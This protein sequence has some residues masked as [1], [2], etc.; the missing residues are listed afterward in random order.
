VGAGSEHC[1]AIAG[2]RTLAEGW[3]SK[4]Q[5]LRKKHDL[6][7]KQ[8]LR[9]R[10]WIINKIAVFRSKIKLPKMKTFLVLVFIGAQK[11]LLTERRGKP[12]N[13]PAIASRW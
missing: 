3:H 2:A 12:T 7:K 6:K 9:K 5:D 8:D 4:K 10:T 13:P 11:E 1:S